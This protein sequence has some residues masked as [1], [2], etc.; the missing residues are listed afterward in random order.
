MWH[1][2]K[3]NCLGGGEAMPQVR[4]WVKTD[5]KWEPTYSWP[6]T[7]PRTNFVEIPK[8]SSYVHLGGDATSPQAGFL[9]CTPQLL[10]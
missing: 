6:R 4:A 2:A 8:H 5:L 1:A 10:I 7:I 3:K 9:N